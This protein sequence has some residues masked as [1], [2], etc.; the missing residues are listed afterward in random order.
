MKLGPSPV[1]SRHPLPE[2]EGTLDKISAFL[3]QSCVG[4]TLSTQGQLNIFFDGGG[5][6][7]RWVP[8]ERP[9]LTIDKKL[10]EVP[11]DPFCAQNAGLGFLQELIKRMG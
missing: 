8:L 3:V 2:G 4:P 11:L 9:S 1:A 5:R 10:R 7:L 6:R